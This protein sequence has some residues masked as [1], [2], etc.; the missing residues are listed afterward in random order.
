[1]PPGTLLSN[2]C[3]VWDDA[4]DNFVYQHLEPGVSPIAVLKAGAGSCG[5]LAKSRLYVA[6]PAGLIDDFVAAAPEQGALE[7]NIWVNPID[8]D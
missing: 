6:A 5:D 7:E 2:L 8:S 3:R 1:V 4:C